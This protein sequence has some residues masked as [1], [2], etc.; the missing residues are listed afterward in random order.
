VYI[1]RIEDLPAAQSGWLLGLGISLVASLGAFAGTG[2]AV[3][4]AVRGAQIRAGSA[5]A[6]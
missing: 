4:G 5:A 3:I 2:Y 6:G 1:Y